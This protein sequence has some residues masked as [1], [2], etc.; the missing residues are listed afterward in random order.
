M[1]GIP[2][3]EVVKRNPSHDD[4]LLPAIVRECM[5]YIEEYGELSNSFSGFSSSTLP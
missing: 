5:D 2:L 4:I 1:F 3:A